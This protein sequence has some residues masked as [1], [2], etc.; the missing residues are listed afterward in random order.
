MRLVK[1]PEGWFWKN[2]IEW[3]VRWRKRSRRTSPDTR[4]K[5]EFAT[6]LATRQRRLSNRIKPDSSAKPSQTSGLRTG[7]DNVSTRNL[8][9]YCVQTEAV[10]AATTAKKITRCGRR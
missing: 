3:P 1:A 5:V 10:T 7:I 9:P 8:T 6:Q 2:V 4:T